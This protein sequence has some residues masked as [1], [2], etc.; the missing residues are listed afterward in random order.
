MY[1]LLDRGAVPRSS[2]K[3]NRKAAHM[4][5][6]FVAK[7]MVAGNKKQPPASSGCL[8]WSFLRFVYFWLLYNFFIQELPLYYDAIPLVSTLFWKKSL[9]AKSMCG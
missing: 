2:T 6:F 4:G 3:L 1:Y 5:G 9:L 8:V 7:A